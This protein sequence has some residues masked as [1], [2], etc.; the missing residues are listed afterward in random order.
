MAAWVGNR[1]ASQFSS[2]L[3]MSGSHRHDFIT[4]FGSGLGLRPAPLGLRG[5]G[6][7]IYLM[8]LS[9]VRI[10]SRLSIHQEALVGI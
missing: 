2:S 8:A 9:A 7:C 4:L 1:Y 3:A 5:V 6:D 10:L